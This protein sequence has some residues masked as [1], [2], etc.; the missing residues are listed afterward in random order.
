MT[1][2]EQSFWEV[3]NYVIG[4]AALLGIYGMW[5]ARSRA[6]Q[7]IELTPITVESGD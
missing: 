4:L 6:E 1:D 7:P 2:G 3:I 5:R